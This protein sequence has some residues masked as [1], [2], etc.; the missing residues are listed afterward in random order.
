MKKKVMGLLMVFV[1]AVSVVGC[2]GKEST[3]IFTGK[4][5]GNEATATYYCKGD[6]VLRQV[7]ETKIPYSVFSAYG[8]STK[9]EVKEL[10]E[11]D[12]MKTQL[13]SL[14]DIEGYSDVL[15]YNDDHLIERAEVDYKA[16]DFDELRTKTGLNVTTDNGKDA[17]I[18]SMKKTI[19]YLDSNGFKEVTE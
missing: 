8:A 13:Q 16:A 10:F 5:N 9:E 11:T 18:V 7:I 15:E 4:V 12:Q 19:E 1:M 2:S 6:E 17:K 14:N 3:R